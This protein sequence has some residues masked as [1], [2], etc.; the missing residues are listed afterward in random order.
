M[1]GS[2]LYM[3]NSVI[4]FKGIN[5]SQKKAKLINKFIKVT[6]KEKAGTVWSTTHG[7]KSDGSLLTRRHM[8]ME[9]KRIK[10]VYA[11][12]NSKQKRGLSVVMLTVVKN[13]NDKT[14]QTN[15]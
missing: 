9:S 4:I 1:G 10:R 8:L 7:M 11:S 13:K 2:F 14:N 12:A 15:L 6:G 3:F 5:M